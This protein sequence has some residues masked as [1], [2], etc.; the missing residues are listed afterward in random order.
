MVIALQVSNLT[1]EFGNKIVLDDINFEVQQGEIFGIIGMSGSGK[2]TLLNH[3]IGFLE[4]DEGEIRYHSTRIFDEKNPKDLMRLRTNLMDVKKLFGFAPQ[5]PSFYP[6]L[7]VKENLE[8]FGALHK[9]NPK[10]VVENAKHLLALTQLDNHQDKLAEHLSGGMQRRLSIMC[11]LIHKPEILILDE[12]TADLDPVL[13][14]ETWKL[15]EAINRMGTTIV[16]ASHFLEELER[17]CDRVAIIKNGKMLQYGTVTEIEEKFGGDT[18]EISIDTTEDYV[19]L[20]EKSLKSR[21]V[22]DIKKDQT[23]I[24]LYTKDP[25]DTLFELARLIHTG[26]VKVLSL[27]VHRPRLR[28]LFKEINA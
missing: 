2:T 25:K 10:E 18:V 24:T 9:L 7:S 15:V 3:L 4:P 23:S 5:A 26:K 6:R 16:V 1:K 8:H 11:G 20:I 19:N 21:A 28:E 13:R 12:P 17:S 27:E 22:Q 14:D